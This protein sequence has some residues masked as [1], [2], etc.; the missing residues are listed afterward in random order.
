ELVES[1][2]LETGRIGY[3]LADK[4][5]FHVLEW[6]TEPLPEGAS[7][8][9]EVFIDDATDPAIEHEQTEGTDAGPAFAPF[10]KS[11]GE[12]ANVKLTVT[13]ATD[14][15]D[16]VEITRWLL[17]SNPVPRRSDLIPVP[18]NL[19]AT[20][21]TLRGQRRR[22]SVEE[23]FEFLRGLARDGRPVT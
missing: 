21:E 2:W 3:G 12:W 23:E 18:I 17:R 8:K 15:E 19:H 11:K 4:K 20:V 5:I 16:R 10:D 7:V 22:A 6:R 13:G 9:A 14:P 1:G